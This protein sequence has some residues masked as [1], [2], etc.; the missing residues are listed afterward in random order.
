MSGRT[1]AAVV[2]AGT[3][4]GRFTVLAEAERQR[5]ASGV[6]LRAF[7]CRCECGTEKVVRLNSLREGTTVSCGCYYM[8][9][10]EENL[11]GASTTHG[12]SGTALHMVWAAMLQRCLNPKNKSYKRYGARGVKVCAE[13]QAN[14]ATFKRDV[15]ER[16]NGM[17][18]DRW[19]DKAG[20]YEPGN[21][22][23]ATPSEQARNTRRNVIVSFD[24]QLM[25]LIEAVERSGADYEAARRSLRNGDGA[26]AARFGITLAEG[27][28]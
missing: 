7:R 20:N 11:R 9:Y 24:G 5:R 15:G 25:T 13:W 3:V 19:P 8:E 28:T 1:V 14:F 16:P 26:V 2:P 27:A 12:E 18:L 4:F 23:W 22:R 10:R 21:V 17:T 6:S